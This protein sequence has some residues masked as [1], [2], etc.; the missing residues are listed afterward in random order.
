VTHHAWL[1][2][3]NTLY[4]PRA[5]A[6][7]FPR[8]R[9]SQDFAYKFQVP[10]DAVQMALHKTLLPCYTTKKMT[11]VMVTTTKNAFCWQQYLAPGKLR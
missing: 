1:V 3:N 5:P 8:G 4:G 11:H 6:E 9:A 10:D 2:A 7:I